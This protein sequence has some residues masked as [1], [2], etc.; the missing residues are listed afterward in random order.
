MG[1]AQRAHQPTLMGTSPPWMA[2]M[3]KTQGAVFCLRF[4]HPTGICNF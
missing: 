1:K 3:Q 4:A 2:E